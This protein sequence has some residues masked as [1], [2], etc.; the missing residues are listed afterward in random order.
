MRTPKSF[1]FNVD[2]GVATITLNRP[3]KLNALTFEVYAELRDTFAAI[4]NEKNVHAIVITGAG[5]G[6]CSGGDVNDI[7]GEL[8]KKD[9]KDLLEFTRMTGALVVNIRRCPQPVI[10]AVNGTAAGAGAVIALSCDLRICAET[11]KFAYLFTKVGLS[12]ADMG[13]CWL[14]PRVVGWGNAARLLMTSDTIDAAEALRIGLVNSVV[15]VDKVLAEA[16]SL[17]KR[18]AKGPAFGLKV[19]KQMMNAEAS[20]TLE[21]AV[22]AEADVQAVC[23]LHPDF[24]EAYQAFIGKREPRFK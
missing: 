15:P 21:A 23:M 11:S 1:L 3:E 18:L 8:F 14:L 2:D 12:G 9:K 20:M 4:G 5:K 10:A 16:T 7:I 17:A 24:D 19:T 13:A 22:E 6:F